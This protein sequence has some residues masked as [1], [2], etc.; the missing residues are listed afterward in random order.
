M[1]VSQELITTHFLLRRTKI[2]IKPP[3]NV[4]YAAKM[5]FIVQSLIVQVLH[6]FSSR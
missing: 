4:N 6:V 1:S 3:F 2:N 5:Q